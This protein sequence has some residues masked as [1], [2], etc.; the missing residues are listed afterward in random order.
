MLKL[1][2]KFFSKETPPTTSNNQELIEKLYELY[3]EENLIQIFNQPENKILILNVYYITLN[4]FLLNILSK[5]DDRQISSVNIYS[6][7]KDIKD[8]NYVIK[9]I[10]PLLENNTIN[11]KIIHDLNELFNSVKFLKSLGENHDWSDK[12]I[13]TLLIRYCCWE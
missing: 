2:K 10:I 9:R 11:I 3:Y 5:Q 13:K 1:L 12:S 4:D 7:F 6:Y 8:I